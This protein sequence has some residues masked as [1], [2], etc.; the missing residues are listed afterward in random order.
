M[1]TSCAKTFALASKGE[2]SVCNVSK[3]MTNLS[4]LIKNWK[5][6]IKLTINISGYSYQSQVFAMWVVN[7]PVCLAGFRNLHISDQM[8][9]IQ[10]SWMNLMVFSLGWRSFKNVTSEF[11]YFAPDLIL[12]Q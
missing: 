12:N 3:Q 6:N 9:L 10:Y 8:T 11:L 4:I 1:S 7:F 2:T 5:V